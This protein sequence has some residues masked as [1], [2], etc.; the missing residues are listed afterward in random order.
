[1]R[2]TIKKG[3]GAKMILNF[4]QKCVYITKISRGAKI[5]PTWD[6]GGHIVFLLEGNKI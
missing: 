5:V 6:P 3:E 4:T 1:M 2:K